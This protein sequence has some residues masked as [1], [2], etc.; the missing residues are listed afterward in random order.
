[1]SSISQTP[2]I[3]QIRHI[4][5]GKVYVGSAINPRDRWKNHRVLLRNGKHHSIH[6]QRAWNKYNEVAFIFEIIEP[7]LFI[8]DLIAREQYWIDTLKAS[9]Q[10]HG[11]NITPTAG[12]PILLGKVKG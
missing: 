9:T 11:Y 8:E 3:Y 6:L 4:A 7:V 1:M 12:S 10:K 5:S 2:S